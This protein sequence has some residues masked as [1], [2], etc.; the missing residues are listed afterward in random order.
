[1]FNQADFDAKLKKA[2]DAIN[3]L[4]KKTLAAQEQMEKTKVFFDDN[5]DTEYEVSEKDAENYEVK[6]NQ[7][8][9]IKKAA[10]DPYSY[11]SANFISTSG[12]WSNSNINYYPTTADY[13]VNGGKSIK[14]DFGPPP[15]TYQPNYY[16]ESDYYDDYFIENAVNSIK[17]IYTDNQPVPSGFL[18]STGKPGDCFVFAMSKTYV[19]Y[20]L[21]KMWVE[22]PYKDVEN[23]WKEAQDKVYDSFHHNKIFA[24]P[25]NN[26]KIQGVKNAMDHVKV[27]PQP[28]KDDWE[29]WLTVPYKSAKIKF[30]PL[31]NNGTPTPL[32]I[33]KQVVKTAVQKTKPSNPKNG[34]L[35]INNTTGACQIYLNDSWKTFTQEDKKAFDEHKKALGDPVVNIQTKK[36]ETKTGMHFRANCG[37]WHEII[38]PETTVIKSING[39]YNWFYSS[40]PAASEYGCG[41]DNQRAMPAFTTEEKAEKVKEIEAKQQGSFETE[42]FINVSDNGKSKWKEI[43][44]K[45]TIT[46]GTRPFHHSSGNKVWY[47]CLTYAEIQQVK[48]NVVHP[49]L[50]KETQNIFVD[51]IPTSSSGFAWFLDGTHTQ[52]KSSIES[53]KEQLLY[54]VQQKAEELMYGGGFNSQSKKKIKKDIPGPTSKYDDYRLDKNEIDSYMS[55]FDC[56]YDDVYSLSQFKSKAQNIHTYLMYDLKLAALK[57]NKTEYLIRLDALEL[58]QNKFNEVEQYYI[59]QNSN[60][61]M[62]L[63][64]LSKVQNMFNYHFENKYGLE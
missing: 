44:S 24:V 41:H 48:K 6:L 33:A 5:K 12:G 29:D 13:Y 30:T 45:Q 55:V 50:I 18:K 17:Q 57:K 20:D 3:E 35:W 2:M 61:G 39:L 27:E 28:K 59:T 8:D 31:D 42:Y 9:Q 7:K 4:S 64:K 51:A 47:M 11:S 1:M 32:P 19:W 36:Q 15:T 22:V 49:E 14:Q 63:K 62:Y 16:A 38:N 26:V 21:E 34:L 60:S 43:H 54:I 23:Y 40:N 53:E 56:I 25:Y 46:V 10:V 58:L 52:E 37:K